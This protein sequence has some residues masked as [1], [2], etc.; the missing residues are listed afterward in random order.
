MSRIEVNLYTGRWD[1]GSQ[2]SA[3]GIGTEIRLHGSADAREY[4]GLRRKLRSVGRDIEY[5][6][7]DG[8][9]YDLWVVVALSETDE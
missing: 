6:C 3:P 2:R 5:V 9:T 1:V 4:D 8:S 7:G